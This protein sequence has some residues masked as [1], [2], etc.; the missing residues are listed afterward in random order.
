MEKLANWLTTLLLGVVIGTCMCGWLYYKSSM[1]YE[2]EKSIYFVHGFVLDKS[3]PLN[4][5][6]FKPKIPMINGK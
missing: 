4:S 5:G 1:H 6:A 2:T 3:N